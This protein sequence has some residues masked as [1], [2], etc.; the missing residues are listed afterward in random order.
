MKYLDMNDEQNIYRTAYD[1]NCKQV[2]I[3]MNEIF[4]PYPNNPNYLVSNRGRIF[5]T[6]TNTMISR[7]TNHYGYNVC[8]I[9]RKGIYIHK[10]VCQTF[11]P[12]TYSDKANQVM[13]IDNNH[14]NDDADN[15]KWAT[16]SEVKI[17]M[18]KFNPNIGPTNVCHTEEEIRR[19]CELLQNGYS[20]SSIMRIMNYDDTVNNHLLISNI[21]VRRSWTYI[22]KD[23]NF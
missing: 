22:S 1:K 14:S 20:N 19:I 23:Y 5:N 3:D 12:D 18:H 17:N 9:D 6:K 2:M 8:S 4:K 11:H 15:I 10:L 16:P 13:H 21:K 7:R